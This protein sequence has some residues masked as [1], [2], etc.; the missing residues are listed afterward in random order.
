VKIVT[1]IRK[2]IKSSEPLSKNDHLYAGPNLK[3]AQKT[4]LSTSLNKL[5]IDLESNE[6]SGEI[7]NP[8]IFDDSNIFLFSF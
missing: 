8:K 1:A 6:T 2:S 7:K 4:D 5:T 3:S